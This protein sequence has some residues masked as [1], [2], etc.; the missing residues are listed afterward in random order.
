MLASAW[1][2]LDQVL[3]VPEFEAN[4]KS[5]ATTSNSS[6]FSNENVLLFDSSV[7][8]IATPPPNVRLRPERIQGLT[9]ERSQEL[10]VFCTTSYFQE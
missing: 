8:K 3:R 4:A 7:E 2:R 5:L 9:T 10:Y 6:F 1:L